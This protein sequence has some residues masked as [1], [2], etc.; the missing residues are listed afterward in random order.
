MLFRSRPRE[1]ILSRSGLSPL[2]LR[3]LTAR[4][5][6]CDEVYLAGYWLSASGLAGLFSAYEAGLRLTLVE[7]AVAAPPADPTPSVTEV[8]LRRTA[9]PYHRS[10]RSEQLLAHA[11]PAF[12]R[13]AANN[14]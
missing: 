10:I 5:Q 9:R 14:A 13:L 2:G 4:L 1:A 12:T 7:D 8:T 6:D 3:A 11:E